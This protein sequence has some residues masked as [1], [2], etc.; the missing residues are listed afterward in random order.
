MRVKIARDKRILRF[1][2]LYYLHNT[3]TV[4]LQNTDQKEMPFDQQI[5]QISEFIKYFTDRK[6]GQPHLRTLI[7]CDDKKY[8]SLMDVGIVLIPEGEDGKPMIK[9]D[10][11]NYM[12]S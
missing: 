12:R 6:R 10:Q 8:E 1:R 11:I 7:R 4:S 5:K 9:Q 3:F 2:E